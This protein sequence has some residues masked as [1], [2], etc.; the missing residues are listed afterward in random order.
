MEDCKTKTFK[1]SN[2]VSSSSQ[3]ANKVVSMYGKHI[4]TSMSFVLQV[5]GA[6]HVH[7]LTKLEQIH[8]P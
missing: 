6:I 8:V 4:V 7:Y 1:L 3:L 5:R 2:L